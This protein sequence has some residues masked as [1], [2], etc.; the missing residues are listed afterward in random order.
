MPTRSPASLG[1]HTCRWM[2]PERTRLQARR[3]HACTPGSMPPNAVRP[4]QPMAPG[5]T[6]AGCINK[7]PTGGLGCSQEHVGLWAP[8]CFLCRKTKARFALLRLSRSPSRV[9][10]LGQ[11]HQ[12]LLLSNNARLSSRVERKCSPLSCKLAPSP[13]TARQGG[14]EQW[15]PP[16]F[17]SPWGWGRGPWLYI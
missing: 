17:R 3:A 8:V 14:L 11:P 15:A 4:P 1:A 16:A 2:C 13:G 12:G 10:W 5:D 9:T 7:R 6:R